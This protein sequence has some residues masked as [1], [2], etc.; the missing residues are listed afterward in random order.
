MMRK[1]ELEPRNESFLSGYRLPELTFETT[2]LPYPSLI[3]IWEFMRAQKYE[4]ARTLALEAMQKHRIFPA[5]ERAAIKIALATA[6][7][8]LGAT[9]IAKRM[10]GRSLDLT[11]NQFSGHNILL[12]IHVVRKD[13]TAAY[14]YL[15]NLPLPKKTPSWD[16]ELSMQEVHVALAAWAWQLGQW[17]Q[18]ADHLHMAYP[19]GLSEM[20]AAIREDWFRLSLYRGLPDDAAAA[21]ATLID[22]RSIDSADELLQTIVQSGWTKQALPLYRKFYSDKPESELLR[23]RLVALCVKEGDMDEA[24]VLASTSALKLAA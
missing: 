10:A 3:P 11:T 23:R 17:D 9:D 5:D 20:P 16:E 4:E 19:A 24:R 15:A 8:K 6:E 22:D 2:D 14:L 1:V 7:F 18:V 13:F 21:A 12:S